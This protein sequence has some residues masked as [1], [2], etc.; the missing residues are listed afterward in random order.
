MTC[1]EF[2]DFLMAYLDH[3][4]DALQGGVFEGHM[5]ECPTCR[6]Y[7]VTYE[8]TIRLGKLACSESDEL[9]EDA[10][11]ALIEAVLAARSSS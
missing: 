10:P 6:E 3:E 8:E 1:Q 7:L 5:D 2:V 4:L 9:P 11:E